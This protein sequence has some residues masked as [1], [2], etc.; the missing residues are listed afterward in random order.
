M[1]SSVAVTVGSAIDEVSGLAFGRVPARRERIVFSRARAVAPAALA[2]EVR[3]R[4]RLELAV[5][6][7]A[8]AVLLRDERLPAL[9][10]LPLPL[11][12]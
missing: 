4:R 3:V 6:L 1:T 2:S 7:F 11:L 12:L 9:P 10:V 5:V 8:F